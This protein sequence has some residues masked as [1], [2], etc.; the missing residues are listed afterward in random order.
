MVARVCNQ[1]VAGRIN[2]NTVW[3]AEGGYGARAIDPTAIGARAA[4]RQS[5]NHFKH[6]ERKERAREKK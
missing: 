2:C 3:I 6:R 4:A 1:K 5:G